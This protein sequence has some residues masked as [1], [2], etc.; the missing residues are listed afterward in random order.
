MSSPPAKKIKPS[1]N[2]RSPNQPLLKG[3]GTESKHEHVPNNLDLPFTTLL[4]L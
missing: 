1:Y 2:Y 3:A 4:P